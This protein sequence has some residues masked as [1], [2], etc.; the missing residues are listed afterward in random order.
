[1]AN[2]AEFTWGQRIGLMIF[3]VTAGFGAME[4]TGFWDFGLDWGLSTYL[5]ITFVGGA[6]GG[7]LLG[8]GS[9]IA[10]LVGGMLAGPGGLLALYYWLKD[11]EST[12]NIA[13]M[14]VQFVGSLPGIGVYFLLKAV[15]A[16]VLSPSDPEEVVQPID[17]LPEPADDGELV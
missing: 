7:F 3:V 11:R 9:P 2:R 6:I 1:M 16:A 15:F 17:S 10:G 8:R 4:L 12:S 13:L 5:V 14:L